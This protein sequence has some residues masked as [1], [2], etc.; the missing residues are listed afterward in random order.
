MLQIEIMGRAKRLE[1]PYQLIWRDE[2]KGAQRYGGKL[3]FSIE[4]SGESMKQIGPVYAI[5]VGVGDYTH[6]G[7]ASLPATVRDAQAIAALLSDST[8]C[9]YP[10]DHVQVITGLNATASTVRALPSGCATP[11]VCRCWPW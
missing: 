1:V 8:L 5:L 6:P 10:P 2:T 3:A 11:R 4:P 9:G 7:F